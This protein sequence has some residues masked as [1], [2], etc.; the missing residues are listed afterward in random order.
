M[1]LLAGLLALAL[2]GCGY[3]VAG[4]TNV[5][6]KEIH[7]IAV[8]AW[9]NAT[10]QYKLA[11]YMAEAMSREMITRTHYTIVADPSKADATLYGTIAN[12]FSNATTY[13]VVTG[14]S[15]GAQIV[16]QIQVRLLARDGKVL[17]I[18]PNL[19]FRDRYEIS[20][21]PGQYLDESQGTLQ[22]L[23]RDVART[24]VS[25]VLENF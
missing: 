11:G 21:N 16:V 23:S 4:S 24:I 10:T 22:R 8:P 15:T 20:V 17:F 1:R 18:R 19:E 7:T 6:P 12:M 5:L 25:S 14:R 3:H 13:D 9:L 2:V